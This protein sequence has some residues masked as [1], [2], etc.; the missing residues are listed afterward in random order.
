MNNAAPVLIA[1][2][3]YTAGCH[4]GRDLYSTI[5]CRLCGAWFCVD[6]FGFDDNARD[7]ILIDTDAEGLAHYEGRCAA[8]R[9]Q[10]VQRHPVNSAWV[11]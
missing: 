5:K 11:R 3:C 9:E 4:Q 1:P 2:E 7:V 10:H 8:C 6:H